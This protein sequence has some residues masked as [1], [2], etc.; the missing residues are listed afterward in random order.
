MAHTRDTDSASSTSGQS[1]RPPLNHQESDSQSES[2]GVHHQSHRKHHHHRPYQRQHTVGHLHHA[3]APAAKNAP[4]QPKLSR[5][6]T[7]PLDENLPTQANTITT[8]AA[9]SGPN[10]HRRVASDAK[11]SSRDSSSGN[12]AKSSSQTKLAKSSSQSKLGK[13]SSQSKL[14][15]SSSQSKLGKSS[16][17]TTLNKSP[18]NTKL[19]KSPSQTKLKR[20]CSH[21]E[22]GKRTRSTELKRASSTTIVYQTQTAGGKSQVHF[23]LG[24]D[25]QED[26]WVD[27]SGSNSPYL[28]RKG[29]INSSNHSVH[30]PDEHPE[31]SRPATPSDPVPPE[32]KEHHDQPEQPPIPSPERHRT[33]QKKYLTSRILQRTPS[34]GAPPQMTA[35]M[36]QVSPQRFTPASMGR[37][38]GTLMGSTQDE[39]TSRFVEAAGSGLTSEGSFYRPPRG[40]FRRGDETPQKPRSVISLAAERDAPTSAPTKEEGGDDS[41]LAPKAA[42]RSAPPAAQTSRTQQ[43][44]NLQRASSVIEPGQAVGG[45]GGVVGHSPLIGVGGPGHDGGNSRDPR[46]GKLLERTGMEYLVVRRY[47][48][49]VSRSLA[50]LNHLPGADKSLRIPRSNL[51]SANGKRSVDLTMRQHTRNVSMPD[52]R[53]PATPK[54]P[55]SVRTNGAASSYEGGD[56]DGRLTDRLSG[57]SLVGGDEEDGTAALLR[58]L[59]DKSMELS[60]STE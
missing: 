6:H 19:N 26:E 18:S 2:S 5:R 56:D 15:K 12:L 22:I 40:E 33:H 28:S 46:V 45:V 54:R 38:S 43:K 55:M 30:H 21:T 37:D 7:A 47:Q 42:R 27:A 16:S 9:A 60:A 48:N 13:S 49:S 14:G 57:S 17:Y 58:N 59:W 39:L 34:H 8:S 25:G 51:A 4:K 35:D 53:R 44:L 24:S 3:R 29:S 23:D 31:S 11:L 52:P 10:S 36:V 20:N 1:K 32:Q 50:R 41:A